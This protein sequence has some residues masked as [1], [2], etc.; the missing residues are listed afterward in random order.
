VLKALTLSLLFAIP[1]VAERGHVAV[2]RLRRKRVP[3]T[4][5]LSPISD[6][7][8][9]PASLLATPAWKYGERTAKSRRIGDLNLP[10]SAISPVTMARPQTR[11]RDLSPRRA[12][13]R[14]WFLGGVHVGV[15]FGIV[16]KVRRVGRRFPVLEQLLVFALILAALSVKRWIS[17]DN[18]K[19]VRSS[20][21]GI[22]L[23]WSEFD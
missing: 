19:L 23:F 13:W 3:D 10:T 9:F 6:S 22:G 12:L 1:A 18:F 14:V 17:F 20:E 2:N 16:G 21:I 7:I 11:C 15:Y 8:A 5:Q 4:F